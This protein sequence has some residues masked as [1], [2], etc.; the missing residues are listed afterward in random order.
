MPFRH[1]CDLLGPLIPGSAMHG[2]GGQGL[3]SPPG[4][5]NGP[6]MAGQRPLAPRG[7]RTDREDG[8]QARRSGYSAETNETGAVMTRKRTGVLVSI[9]V[10]AAVGRGRGW[11]LWLPPQAH[12]H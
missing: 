9:A 7:I 6:R 10:L 2:G 11:P 4:G 1:G 5:T 3:R 12:R 8:P